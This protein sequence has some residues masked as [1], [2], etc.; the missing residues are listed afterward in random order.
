[1]R[2][3]YALTL[4]VAAW[5]SA[6]PAEELT[7]DEIMARVAAN[8]DRAVKH[9]K[10]YVFEQ[11]ARVR[12]TKGAS[13]L[14]RE[15]TRRYRITP[16]ETGVEREVLDIDV[17]HRKD[18]EN[19]ELAGMGA[20]DAEQI[21]GIDADLA[22]EFHED[23]AGENDSR[24]GL[25]PELFPLTADKQR[26]FVFRLNGLQ[27]YRGRRVYSVSFEPRDDTDTYDAHW[28]GEVLIDEKEFQ[29]VLVTSHLAQ[30]IPLWVRTV[31]GVNIRQ[32]GFKLSYEQFEDGVWFPVSYGGEFRIKALHLFR[33]RAAVSLVN[34]EFRRTDVEST[35]DFLADDSSR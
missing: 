10:N 4:C 22:E 35:V 24:D 9:R 25:N 14:K 12:I 18:G 28:A 20:L 1:M 32:V 29:P 19:L 17:I 3:L 23:L 16:T 21:E 13:K 5:P 27:G 6:A 33:R 15:E 11:R 8:Q 26:G 2:T 30:K 34:E 7:A 31:F